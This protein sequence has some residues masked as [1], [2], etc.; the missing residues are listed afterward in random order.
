[1]SEPSVKREPLSQDRIVRAALAIADAEGLDALTM[2]RLALELGAAPMTA[3]SHF[4]DKRELL[5]AVVD[6]VMAEVELPEADGRW[7]KPIRRLAES[8]RRALLAHSAVMPAVHVYGAGGPVALTVID[9]A[10]AIMRGAGFADEQ[11]VAAVDTVYAFT[12]GALSL[13]LAE[14]RFRDGLDR[15]LAG[16]AAAGRSPAT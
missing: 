6:A 15:V 10:R 11:A 3:Y 5:T 14:D 2:R 13:E 9:R 1:M 16:I 8:F 7:R 4:R 12:L